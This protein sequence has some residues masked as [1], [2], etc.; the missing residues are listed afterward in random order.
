MRFKEVSAS[1]NDTV[2]QSDAPLRMGFCCASNFSKETVACTS[3][4]QS[5]IMSQS[6]TL[7]ALS[8][9]RTC[10]EGG[11]PT[12]PCA[13]CALTLTLHLDRDEQGSRKLRS[14]CSRSIGPESCVLSRGWPLLSKMRRSRWQGEGSRHPAA[15]PSF[16][17]GQSH[18]A[19]SEQEQ[20]A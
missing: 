2:K 19:S 13:P 4:L 3:L 16:K 1:L 20:C 15:K 18:L 10:K 5:W 8:R 6:L 9:L 7:P 12:P 14:L 11:L 17:R